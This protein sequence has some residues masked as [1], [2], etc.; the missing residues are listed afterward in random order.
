MELMQSPQ[1]IPTDPAAL[2]VAEAAKARVQAAYV[3]ALQRPRSE[4]QARA[5]ILNACRRPSFADKVEYSKPVGKS[6]VRGPS[7]R[8]AELA[9]REW[10]NILTESFTVFE[11]DQMRRVRIMVCDLETNASFSKEVTVTKTVERRS[12]KDREVISERTNSK[13]ETVYIVKATDEEMANKE[14]A[15]ISKAIRNEGLRL[16]PSD[17]IEEALATARETQRTRDAKDPAAAKKR[18]VD[19]FAGMGIQPKHLE[20]YLGHALDHISPAEL[21][22]LRGIYQAIKDGEATWAEYMHLRESQGSPQA[23]QAWEELWPQVLKLAAERGLPGDL[24]G[25][26][27]EFFERSTAVLR[28]PVQEVLK[29]A[30]DDFGGPW[31]SYLKWPQCKFKPPQGPGE[32][33]QQ[34]A[35]QPAKQPKAEPPAAAPEKDEGSKPEAEAAAPP[36]AQEPEQGPLLAG[37]E[38]FKQLYDLMARKKVDEAFKMGLSDIMGALQVLDGGDLTLATFSKVMRGLVKKPIELS[39]IDR[40]IAAAKAKK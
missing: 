14:A 1:L 22:E 23:A 24:A 34:A 27:R 39:I 40:A 7:I 11:N 35:A 6:R 10:S 15:L 19:A 25:N 3:M 17:I 5:R 20:Q 30:L 28:L 8:F 38:E 13:G 21:E 4:D 2:A 33:Q 29:A 31:A 37:E 18:V 26:L 9:L 16:I 36:E 32:D 12:A